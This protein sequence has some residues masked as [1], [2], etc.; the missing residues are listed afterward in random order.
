MRVLIDTDTHLVEPPTTWR[1]YARSVRPGRRPAPDDR[2]AR[3][4][5]LFMACSAYPHA[6]GTMAALVDYAGVGVVPEKDTG[7]FF[8]DNA[9][10]L[11]R[12]A[13]APGRGITPRRTPSMDT[14]TAMS[15][16]PLS[17]WPPATNA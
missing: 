6:E 13:A 1:E 14:G 12:L 11:L 10:Y 15:S 8:G 2:R 7:G 16:R 5:D 9:A 4:G 17:P 3:L